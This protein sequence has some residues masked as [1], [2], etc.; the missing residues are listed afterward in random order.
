VSIALLA[1]WQVGLSQF[2]ICL[3]DDRWQDF[4]VN[5][6]FGFRDLKE[7]PSWPERESS[8]QPAGH[9][10]TNLVASRSLTFLSN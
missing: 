5:G 7:E 6:C 4:L 10:M 2:E 3:I 1:T 9:L 8:G